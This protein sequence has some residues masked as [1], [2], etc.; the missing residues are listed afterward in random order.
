MSGTRSLSYERQYF[1]VYEYLVEYYS[2]KSV[3]H[4]CVWLI[5]I[6]LC[7]AERESDTA[8]APHPSRF[9]SV[10]LLFMNYFLESILTKF[11]FESCYIRA[12]NLYD[13]H[14]YAINKDLI[15]VFFFP[16]ENTVAGTCKRTSRL[17]ERQL[18]HEI[19]CRGIFNIQVSRWTR[20][21]GLDPI[22]VRTNKNP[23][24]CRQKCCKWIEFR[25]FLGNCLEKSCIK[26][27][28]VA[29]WTEYFNMKNV[30]KIVRTLE[31]KVI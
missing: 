9:P 16:G 28:K 30:L 31:M 11:L 19:I 17:L 3:K 21:I 15:N 22:L 24:M 18:I 8:H 12:L 2:V 14:K 4:E 6:L 23:K 10:G 26:F 5:L 25:G 13:T 20:F 27:Y 29:F 7:V 1:Y